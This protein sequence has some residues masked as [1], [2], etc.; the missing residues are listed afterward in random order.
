MKKR[1]KRMDS[2]AGT[3]REKELEEGVK[4]REREK[5]GER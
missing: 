1:G 5:K 3:E 4:K 2:V